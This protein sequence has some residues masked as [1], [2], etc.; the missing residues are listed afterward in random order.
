MT[1]TWCVARVE[2]PLVWMGSSAWMEP[3]CPSPAA[4]GMTRLVLPDAVCVFQSWAEEWGREWQLQVCAWRT[5][6]VLFSSS[7]SAK[8]EG[9]K[10]KQ[11]PPLSL[12]AEFFSPQLYQHVGQDT[13][14]LWRAPCVAAPAGLCPLDASCSPGP[15]L[16][17]LEN[18]SR[19]P[20]AVRGIAP[21]EGT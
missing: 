4:Q 16:R 13:S 5:D 3:L 10:E 21:G 8:D 9:K 18:A 11:K 1:W 15:E 12:R 2:K 14:L 20:L 17:Q 7:L 19:C 6:L